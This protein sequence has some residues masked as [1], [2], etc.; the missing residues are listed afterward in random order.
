MSKKKLVHIAFILPF[1]V[2]SQI[3]S[4]IIHYK[5]ANNEAFEGSKL[6]FLY[7]DEEN[8]I[9]RELSSELNLQLIF[10]NKQSIFCAI[11]LPKY[12]DEQFNKA[13]KFSNIYGYY[14]KVK[15]DSKIEWYNDDKTFGL[16]ILQFDAQLDWK[17]TEEY[18]IIDGYKCYKAIA[19]VIDYSFLKFPSSEITAWYCPDIPV[20]LGPKRFGNLPGL[21]FEITDRTVT[22]QVSK[23]ILNPNDLLIFN[24]P[25][26]GKKIS[27]LGYKKLIDDYIDEM[28]R[29]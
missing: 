10:D 14:T 20:N 17:L 4:G 5:I 23:I 27:P 25:F 7:T 24:P 29:D 11:P 6:D 21:I 3:N 28:N 9:I 15:N 26:Q 8:K 19:T 1:F 2:L 22:L 16:L 12:T 13:L 18:K